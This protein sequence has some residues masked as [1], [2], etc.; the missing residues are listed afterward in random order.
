MQT[1]TQTRRSIQARQRTELHRLFTDVGAFAEATGRPLRPY[2]LEAARAIAA[3]VAGR[4]GLTCTVLMPRQAGKNELSAQL[5]AFLLSRNQWHGGTLVK[6]APT[7]RPQLHTSIHRLTSV[8]RRSPT[9]GHWRLRDG[10]AL[11]LG[12]ASIRF[13]SAEPRSNV[14]GATAGLLLECDEAQ[15][16]DADKWDRE[17]RPMGSTANATSVLYG[18]PWTEDTLLAR[19]IALNREAESRDGV[20]RHFQVDW[21]TVAEANPDYGRFVAAEIARLGEHHPIIRTQ[22]LLGT[23]AAAG[24]LLDASQLGLLLG[25][26]QPQGGPDPS[27]FGP[28]VYVAG[29]DVAGQDEEDPAG[30]LGPASPRRDST[31][32]T[33]AFAEQARVSSLVVEPRF[34]VVRQYAWRG[35]RHRELFPRILALVRDHWRCAAV[36]VDATGVG[37]GLAAF[38]GAALGPRVVT[39]FVYSA[40]SKSKLAFDFLAAVNA[41]RF[42]LHAEGADEEA[43]DTRRELLRQCE[44]AEYAMRAH[45]TMTFFVPAHRGHDDHLNAAALLVQAVPLGRLRTAVGRS[46]RSVQTGNEAVARHAAAVPFRGG[47]AFI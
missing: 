16:V 31:V 10:Y 29:L 15:A 20:R 34:S 23:V 13:L 38:L 22:Y 35:P 11:H 33:V 43:N 19:E 25:S 27:P 9:P 1:Q 32:L 14:V 44:A 47:P 45:Q 26:H 39:S 8:L 17:F 5:E 42:K 12:A 40:A 46:S 18:T 36:V 6:C 2:Q 24:R 3:S 28:G 30:L 21:T 37:G 41:G 4:Q 7:F